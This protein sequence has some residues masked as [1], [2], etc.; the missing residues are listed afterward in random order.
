MTSFDGIL[1][2]QARLG[3]VTVLLS[4]GEATFSDLRDLLELTQGNLGMHVRKLEEASYVEA[5]KCF[6]GRRPQTTYRLTGRGKA[7]FLAHVEALQRVVD[8]AGPGEHRR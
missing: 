8:G 4:R 1:L 2:S 5:V 3:V 7:A 6:V